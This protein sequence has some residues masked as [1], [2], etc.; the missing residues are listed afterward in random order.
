MS[1]KPK[2]L[3]KV[4]LWGV[5]VLA[6]LGILGY[7]LV[8]YFVVTSADETTYTSTNYDLR[9]LTGLSMPDGVPWPGGPAKIEKDDSRAAG[10]VR[11]VFVSDSN[12]DLPL[13]DAPKYLNTFSGVAVE[14]HPDQPGP[15]RLACFA[16]KRVRLKIYYGAEN[17]QAQRDATATGANV[18]RFATIIA[19]LVVALIV[20]L[21]AGAVR[22]SGRRS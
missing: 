12:K 15:G 8:T 22:R 10:T 6:S 2:S 11:C 3:W 20:T 19:P 9:R 13:Q 5:A 16:D 14:M 4:V 21:V 17:I 1:G 7:Q 18:E